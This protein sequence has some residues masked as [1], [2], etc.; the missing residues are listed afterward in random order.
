MLR[1]I[2]PLM[3]ALALL[4]GQT[5][6]ACTC[7]DTGPEGLST[8]QKISTEADA[9][10]FVAVVE[11]I[12]TREV[13]EIINAKGRF[14][15]LVDASGPLPEPNEFPRIHHLVATFKPIHVWKGAHKQV[16]EV[17]TGVGMGDCGLPFSAGQKVL[18]YAYADDYLD[19]LRTDSCGR[20][21]LYRDA[22][23][24]ADVLSKKYRKPVPANIEM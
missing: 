18:L 12:S 14:V 5:A 15:G 24:D 11:I 19:L 2:A 22:A 9:T 3:F 10:N 21:N 8:E 6:S 13:V 16:D 4:H 20:T 17:V 1:S 23:Q 7:I